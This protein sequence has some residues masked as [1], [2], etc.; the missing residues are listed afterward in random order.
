MII[1][2]ANT[3]STGENTVEVEEKLTGEENEIAFNAKYLLDLF[4]NIDEETMVFEMSGPLNA[5]VFK[6]DGDNSFLHLIM[7]IKVEG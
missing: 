2:S 1:V 7:P 5:G 4:A 3:P 6:I